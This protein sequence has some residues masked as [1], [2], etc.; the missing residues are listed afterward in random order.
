MLN[1]KTANLSTR[2]L[3]LA[4]MSIGCIIFGSLTLIFQE[5][6]FST[7]LNSQLTVK[8]GTAAFNAWAETPI[9][10]YTKFYFFDM[11]NPRDLFH[12]HEKP[13]IE[14]RGPYTF[15]ET[16]KKVDIQWHPNGTVT[17][18]RL[19]YWY[20]ERDLSVGPLTDVIT[21]INVPVVGS[22]EFVRGSFFMEWGISD[23]LATLEATIFVKKT[24]G[25]LL[26]DGYEDEVLEM[27]TE[28]EMMEDDANMD[29]FGWFY[30]RNGT[31]WSDGTIEM[32]TGEDD[33]NNLGKIASWEGREFTNAF[34]GECG[35]VTGSADGLF[36][37][38]LALVSDTL[39]MFSTDLCRPIHFSKSGHQTLHGIPVTT[40]E[41]AADNFANTTVCPDNECY[42]N[43][44]PSGV[45]N[46]THCKKKSPAF[47][48]RPHFYQADDSYRQA[49]QYGLRPDADKHESKFWVEPESSIPVKVEMRLQ[50]NILLR[51][52][53][54]IDYLFKNLQ[55]VMYPVFW[56]ESTSTLP[57][58]MAAPLNMLVMLPWIMSACGIFSIVTS[59]IIIFF[60][61]ICNKIGRN[62]QKTIAAEEKQRGKHASIIKQLDINYSKVPVK[63]HHNNELKNDLNNVENCLLDSP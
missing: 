54:G 25:E 58:H 45:Q 59:F 35:R 3:L 32:F 5:K 28:M 52:V 36:P 24:V 34:E 4:V 60:M 51:K 30:N 43:N 33:M 10:V 20:F 46:V 47:V 50:L 37:P 31:T 42:Q 26:F 19:K 56:F 17:Y 14:E 9:P 16:Q 22:A 63:D 61:I 2:S 1:M 7:I 13:I 40:F 29:K 18:K 41:L 6:I 49:F 62:K 12:S 21:T 15:R 23:M 8:D 48:S 39:S 27:G 55:E 57:E 53:E 11:L 38:G 44:I